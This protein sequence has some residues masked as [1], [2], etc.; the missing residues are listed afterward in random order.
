MFHTRLSTGSLKRI[1]K[2]VKQNCLSM[3]KRLLVLHIFLLI[4]ILS[5]P[6]DSFSQSIG[7]GTT[8]PDASAA[9]DITATNKGLL[10]PRINIASI[11]A[12][13]NPAR[14]LLV[15]DSVTN[16]L[17]AN[18]GTPA[19]PNWQPIAG[20]SSAGG[21]SLTGNSGINP[22]NQ[23]IGIT[24]NQPLRFRTNNIQAGELHPVT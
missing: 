15:Y 9:L 6:N 21:W 3:K 16:Q 23:F 24:D 19:A 10:I 8:T 4:S 2:L 22:V 11:N 20:N 12:I 14:G 5:L 18:T 17:M 7:I 1:N 13:V